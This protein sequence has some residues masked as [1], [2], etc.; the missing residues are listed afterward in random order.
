MVI[1]LMYPRRSETRAK[2][3]FNVGGDDCGDEDSAFDPEI[4]ERHES[5]MRCGLELEPRE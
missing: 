5:R 4:E 1:A 3:E 2:K